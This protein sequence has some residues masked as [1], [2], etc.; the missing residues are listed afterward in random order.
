MIGMPVSILAKS[1]FRSFLVPG[2]ILFCALGLAPGGL[3]LALRSK[4]ESRIAER[5]NCFK[6]MHW[7]WTYSIYVAFALIT[8]IQFETYFLQAVHW[9]HIF[10]TELAVTIILVALLP[11]VRAFY[12]K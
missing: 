8:W 6:D 4:P 5:I 9:L 3:I 2:I 7:S 1:P 10:Y 11:Q 12:R